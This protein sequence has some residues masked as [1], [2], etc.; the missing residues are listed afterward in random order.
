[1]ATPLATSP[2]LL[3]VRNADQCSGQLTFVETQT[4]PNETLTNYY[5]KLLRMNSNAQKGSATLLW[6]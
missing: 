3:L 1:M 5:Q 2:A 4:T 6:A